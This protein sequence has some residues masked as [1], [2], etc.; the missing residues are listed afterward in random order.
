M[1]SLMNYGGG[2]GLLGTIFIGA[3]AGWI[4]EKLT[5]S[6]HGL[7]TNIFVG[8][9]GSVIGSS[10]ADGLGFKLGEIFQG[11]FWG[12]LVVSVIGAV[13]LII[14]YRWVRSRS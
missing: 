14:G 11:W 3:L 10:L 7:L 2:V 5:R 9:A 13:I 4:A 6:S 12:N 8:I 1:Q